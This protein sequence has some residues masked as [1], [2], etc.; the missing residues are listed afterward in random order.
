[1]EPTKR[2]PSHHGRMLNLEPTERLP[3]YSGRMLNLGPTERLPSHH[4][5][6]KPGKDKMTGLV[7]PVGP[8]R[9]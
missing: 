3:S 5:R 4:G 2:L 9:I 6:I 8:E 7:E 1:M